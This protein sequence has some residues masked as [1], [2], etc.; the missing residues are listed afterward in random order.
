MGQRFFDVKGLS[1]YMCVSP[2]TI[3]NEISKGNF[4]TPFRKIFGRIRFDREDVDHFLN[5]LPTH[6]NFKMDRCKRSNER[7][8]LDPSLEMRIPEDL[9]LENLRSNFPIRA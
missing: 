6:H 9:E 3:Y 1:Q 2:Q 4:P 5:K 8:E 7:T